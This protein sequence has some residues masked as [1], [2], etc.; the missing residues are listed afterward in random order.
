MLFLAFSHLSSYLVP[1]SIILS[2]V[3]HHPFQNLCHPYV[4][5]SS[6]LSPLTLPFSFFILLTLHPSFICPIHAILHFFCHHCFLH[7]FPRHL[8]FSNFSIFLI[9]AKCIISKFPENSLHVLLSK[10]EFLSLHSHCLLCE[11]TFTNSFSHVFAP[12]SLLVWHPSV[13]FWLS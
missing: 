3:L 2:G 4:L 5:D 9:H 10:F 13:V 6:I 11:H 8:V 7:F 12:I 1:S